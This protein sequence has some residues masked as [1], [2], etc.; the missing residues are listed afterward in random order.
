MSLKAPQF[1][2]YLKMGQCLKFS[3]L[4][5]FMDLKRGNLGNCSP[6]LPPFREVKGREFRELFPTIFLLLEA[7]WR[8][9]DYDDLLWLKILQRKKI[10]LLEFFKKPTSRII[11]PKIRHLLYILHNSFIPVNVPLLRATTTIIHQTKHKKSAVT[12]CQKCV[13]I[14]ALLPN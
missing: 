9:S 3:N 11:L 5:L 14:I 2:L 13:L 7:N 10:S 1:S 4:T 12:V 8:T 6:N